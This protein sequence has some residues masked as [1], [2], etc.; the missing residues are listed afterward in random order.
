MN[1]EVAQNTP[2]PKTSGQTAYGAMAILDTDN[3]RSDPRFPMAVRVRY[4]RRN[5]FFFEYT[6]NI[7]RGGMFIGTQEPRE[8]GDRFFFEL[9]VPGEEEPFRLLGEVR[10]RVTPEEVSSVRDV[11]GEALEVGMG[12]AFIF[13]DEAQQARFNDRVVTMLNDA[14][15][16]EITKELLRR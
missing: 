9:D 1:A 11:P 15:G 6:R 12:I 16:P 8:V 2:A 14:F 3:R 10:W 5:A 13:D 7:S 4:P